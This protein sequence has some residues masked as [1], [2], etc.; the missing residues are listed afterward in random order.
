MYAFNAHTILTTD[1]IREAETAYPSIAPRFHWGS[2]NSI[3]RFLCM[4]CR[5]M[6]VRLLGFVPFVFVC[7]PFSWI[8]ASDYPFGLL[9]LFHE[10]RL[11]IT[12][13][14]LFKLFYELRLLITPF[15]LF[16]L[17]HELRF[18]LPLWFIQTFP[19]IT[20]S[21]YPFGLF[22]LFWENISCLREDLDNN[23]TIK[24]VNKCKRAK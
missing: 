15:G 14:G 21:D 9:K 17:F 5:L 16:K 1:F 22:K 10:L 12:P 4:L 7:V 18:W 13:F 23:S 8:T 6:S 20:A 3:F 19:W 2:C 11:L 24:T